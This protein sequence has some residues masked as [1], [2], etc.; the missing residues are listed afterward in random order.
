M[1]FSQVWRVN[2]LGIQYKAEQYVL[3][4]GIHLAAA[5]GL[6]DFLHF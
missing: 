4:E 6:V 2:T 5:V 1:P 3:L